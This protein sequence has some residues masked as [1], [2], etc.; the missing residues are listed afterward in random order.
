[1]QVAEFARLTNTQQLLAFCRD[2]FKTV[3]LPNQMVADGSFPQELRRK[4]HYGYS[5]FNIEA[6]AIVCYNLSIH[7]SKLYTLV[8]PD[9][10]DILLSRSILESIITHYN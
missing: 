7:G 6:M 5:L 2:R 3:L 8:L 1:M 4:N 10:L 9:A